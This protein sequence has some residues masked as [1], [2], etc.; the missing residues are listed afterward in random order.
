MSVELTRLPAASST[1]R[2][3]RLSGDGA[4]GRDR[5]RQQALSAGGHSGRRAM[6]ADSSASPAPDRRRR[7]QGEEMDAVVRRRA[8]A[9][10]RHQL[11]DQR[12][13]CGLINDLCIRQHAQRVGRMYRSTG[14]AATQRCLWRRRRGSSRGVTA[15]TA[16]RLDG[17]LVRLCTRPKGCK[18][19]GRPHGERSGF[20]ALH[21]AG[22]W[23]AVSLRV[24]IAPVLQI[25][26]SGKRAAVCGA[27]HVSV[28]CTQPKTTPP[29]CSAEE[30][31]KTS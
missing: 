14:P 20:S 7:N 2:R 8:H 27:L 18:R 29:D 24:M 10:Q 4:A 19:A 12:N 21:A 3:S 31:C 17:T 22:L 6:Q 15:G 30:A 25:W 23:F 9:A 13:A 16:A 28:G 5:T 26:V 11:I 1:K